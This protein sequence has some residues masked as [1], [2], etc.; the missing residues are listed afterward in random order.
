LKNAE[1]RTDHYRFLKEKPHF[2]SARNAPLLL[3][4][5]FFTAV[6]VRAFSIQIAACGRERTASAFPIYSPCSAL[7]LTKD[8]NQSAL[9]NSESLGWWGFDV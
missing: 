1:R 9:N 2:L 8:A 3:M 7:G 5:D 4:T 6:R